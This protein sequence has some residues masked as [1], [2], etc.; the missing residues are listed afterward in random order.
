MV[1]GVPDPDQPGVLLAVRE[2]D[3]WAVSPPACEHRRHGDLPTPVEVRRDSVEAIPTDPPDGPDTFIESVYT[4]RGEVEYVATHYR[5]HT[6]QREVG[7]VGPAPG[8]PYV[9]P[10][11]RPVARSHRVSDLLAADRRAR[12]PEEDQ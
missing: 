6:T 9:G 12:V 7:V 5:G 11:T 10:T 3:P 8:G 1:R 4:P 2:P